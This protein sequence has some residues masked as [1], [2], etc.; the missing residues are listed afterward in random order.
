MGPPAKFGSGRAGKRAKGCAPSRRSLRETAAFSAAIVWLALFLPATPAASSVTSSA[1]PLR[2]DHT[3][4]PDFAFGATIDFRATVQ[5]APTEVNFYFR[6]PSI[7]QFQVRPL[8]RSDDGSYVLAFDT[9]TLT[10]TMFSYY[11]EAVEGAS[12]VFFPAGAPAQSI[13]LQSNGPAPTPVP[14]DIP[15]PQAAEAAYKLPVNVTATGQGTFYSRFDTPGSSPAQTSGNARIFVTPRPGATVGVSF[16]SN[17]SYTHNPPDGVNPFG[18]SNLRATIARGRHAVRVG[19]LEFNESEYSISGQTRRGMDYLFEGT[20][21]YV[22]GFLASS[23]QVKGFEGLGYPKASVRLSGAAAGYR[24]FGDAVSLK[25]LVLSG[26]DDPNQGV[27]VAMSYAPPARQ[28]SLAAIVQETRLFA[29]RLN[30]KLELAR[31]R[32]DPDL[33]DGARATSDSAYSVGTE[34]RVGPVNGSARYRSIGKDFNS[35]GLQYLANDRRGFDANLGFFSGKLMLQGNYAN[36]RD[37]VKNDPARFTTRSGSG[38]ISGVLTLPKVT[39]NAGYRLSDQTSEMGGLTPFSQDNN[40]REATAGAVWTPSSAASLNLT[41]VTSDVSSRSTPAAGTRALTLSSGLSFRSGENF[42]LCPS[43]SWSR[44]VYPGE[45]GACI[46]VNA[47]IVAEIYFWKRN[48]SFSVFGTGNRMEQ[49]VVGTTRLWNLTTALNFQAGK[50]VKFDTITLSL[51][52]SWNQMT[53]AG[54]R[55]VDARVYLQADVAF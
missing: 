13:V 45:T 26:R 6:T 21:L 20:K 51:R 41:L 49:P 43:V 38:G 48:L 2:I 25:A 47:N 12:R 18:V 8:S 29:Q 14:A 1:P 34:F 36:E 11:L 31:S 32:Y 37:N 4:P 54:N 50:F 40:T 7:E 5:G 42:S 27:N 19:D 23:R 28:G 10:E 44:S 9:S 52:G 53:M 22:R 17:L 24:L 35:V 46:G 30:L 15:T 55:V 39:F 16:D 33:A 3:P